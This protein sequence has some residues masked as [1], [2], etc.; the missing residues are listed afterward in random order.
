[1]DETANLGLAYI[2]PSQAQKYVT[3]NEALRDLDSIVQLAVLD[4]DL[5]TP[6]GGPA[7][8]DRYLVATGASGGWSG[9]SGNIAAFQDGLW[10]FYLPQK[11]WRVWIEDEALLVAWTGTLWQAVGAGSVNPVSMLG[12]IATADTTNRLS[13]KSDAVLFSN[14][15]VTPGSGDMRIAVTKASSIRD[16]AVSL[17]DSGS[18]RAMLGLLGDDNFTIKTSPDGTTFHQ[19]ISLDKSTGHVG[20][21]TTG[22]GTNSLSV[23]GASALLSNA[24]GD[25]RLTLSKSASAQTASLLLQDSFSG[26]AEIGL[27]GDDD[28]HFKVSADGSTWVDNIRI[29]KSSGLLSTVDG[30]VLGTASAQVSNLGVKTPTLAAG[31]MTL[32]LAQKDGSSDPT[33]QSPVL[34]GMRSVTAASGAFNQRSVAAALTLTVP[35]GATL[36][37]VSGQPATLYLYAQDNAGTLELAIGVPIVATASSARRPPSAPARRAPRRFTP[38]PGEAACPCARSPRS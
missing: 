17:E 4:R 33:A 31:A 23:A 25:F 34:V 38:P 27:A 14:D 7:A 22:D 28:L 16:A 29:G 36:G 21:G 11:G 30:Q 6:P 26:R 19:A 24:G 2:M 13:V 32:K 18:T 3:H 10:L 12:V 35:S 15:D 8:G 9:H 5:S 37:T 20:I 1:M